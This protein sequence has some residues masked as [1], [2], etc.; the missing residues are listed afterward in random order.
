ML[1]IKKVLL[2][3]H[4]VGYFEREGDVEN[5]ATIEL[6]FK[7]NEMNDV[8]K[9]L[10]V[11]DLSGGLIS[12]ISYESTKPVEKQLE[13]IAI[14]L[15]E[16]NALTGLLS[17]V[18]G[19]NVRVVV[20]SDDITG[21]VTGI[22]AINKRLH[23]MTLTT[24][25]ITI[26]VDGE[27]LRTYDILELKSITFL[28][29][30]LKSDLN[31]LLEVLISAKKK[32]AK[33][34]T[35]YAKGEGKRTLLATYVVETPVWKASYR[36]L[37][38]EEK[39]TI[40]GW[41]LVDNT[42]DEDWKNVSLT[43]VAGLPISFIH[44]LYSPRYKKRPVVEVKEEE[45]YAPPILEEGMLCEDDDFGEAEMEAPGTALLSRPAAPPP[46]Q[47]E[48]RMKMAP[49]SRSR[50]Q[51]RTAS[52]PVQTRTVEVGD[53]FQY[54]IENPVTVKRNQSALVPILQTTFDADKVAVYNREVREKNPMSAMFIKNTTGLTLEGGPVTVMEDETYVG[55]AM[56]ETMKPEE[57]RIVPYS[58]ELGCVV[59]SDNESEKH[60]IHR[61]RIDSGYMYLDYFQVEKKKYKIKNKKDKK[62]DL[63][64]E[65]R[66][67]HGWDLID[68]KEPFETTENFY[69]FRFDV[70]AKKSMSFT[71]KEKHMQYECYSLQNLRPDLVSYWATNG[72]V[73]RATRN[74]LDELLKFSA[75][76]SDLKRDI[77]E[78]EEEV[79]VIH[80]DQKR[81]RENLKALGESSDEKKLRERYVGEMSREEDRLRH[82]RRNIK[83]LK[84]KKKAKEIELRKAINSIELLREV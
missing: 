1:P 7:S 15:P 46:M 69:R 76:I 23:D 33:K 6:Q 81:L 29:E 54:S 64:L 80:E 44:D 40:Q 25:L 84:E 9:S 47:G 70:P 51:A 83:E 52:M 16:Q 2:Y 65:H 62:I 30:N 42:Q 78:N 66:F 19:A 74:K 3:K 56:L 20:G 18:K 21:I 79:R 60:N 31:H 77:K 48:V 67:N 58:V 49:L 75:Q 28:D 32:D 36:I 72:Y 13:D 34:L 43:L 24:Y 45:A 12:S 57:E 68:T 38:E 35:I 41:A 82:L 17:Q 53:L 39:P 63:F 59:T 27:S 14:R 55:E 8:L 26:L 4:G 73:D 10:T 71:V 37:L 22:Q 11:L 5:D 50:A 61:A